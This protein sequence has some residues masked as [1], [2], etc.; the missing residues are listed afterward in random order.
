[1]TAKKKKTTR[2]P[3]TAKPTTTT[4]STNQ[5]PW[6]TISIVLSVLLVALLAVQILTPRDRGDS[7][8]TVP[9]DTSQKTK[10]AGQY[11][12]VK[13]DFYVMSQCPYGTQVVDAIAPVLEKLGDIV[14]FNL[15]FIATDLGNGNFNSL[16]GQPEVE[17]NI[18]QLCAIK[19][20][21]VNYMKMLVCV[22]K[23]A[24]AIPGN[25]E[26]CAKSTGLAVEKI[27]ACYE[28]EE[29][30]QLL[31][32][33][34]V[35]T[36]KV[37]ASGSPTIYLNDQLYQGGRDALS[38]TRAICAQLNN[39]PECEGLP[40][41]SRD[42]DCM[43]EANKI[44]KC[45]NAGQQ[46]AKC[47]YVDPVKV[48]VTV[49][50]DR[51]CV[52][53]DTTRILQV[54]RQL[55]P[56][57]VLK[58]VDVS[59]AEGKKL[60]EDYSLTVAPAY[61]FDGNIVK[62]STWSK[63]ARVKAAFE[64]TGDKYK[65]SDAASGAKH[66][67]SEEAKKAYMDAIGL[68]PGDGRPQID[69]F[70]MSYCPYGNQAEEAIEK[71]YQLLKDKAEYNPHYVIYSNYQGGGPQ[72]CLDDESKYCSM[73]G[74]QELNQNIRELCVNKHV[75][76]KEY[77]E[78]VLAANKECNAGNVDTCWEAVAEGLGLDT[79]K[80]KKCEKD[81]GLTIAAAEKKLNDILKITGSPQVFVEG[82][83]YAGAR[84]G[85]GYMRALCNKIDDPPEACSQI[86][87]EEPAAAAAAA[88][89]GGCS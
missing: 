85:A 5:N 76:I 40:A 6:K 47:I 65:L 10:P 83:E 16:H 44:G 53:C 8:T 74:V 88:P 78:F 68:T 27:R 21:P 89:Q 55:F 54:I 81:E 60:I 69:F 80:I 77:F 4:R 31:S 66:F 19:H 50:N 71:A 18:V 24:R 1:M 46:G 41:C 13:L 17:G 30:K 7:G 9:D 43:A 59:D 73:H 25:W 37:G 79:D 29:G 20:E 58:L 42:E 84:T 48:E 15:H 22:N 87:E 39:H 26:E 23:N 67:V 75:G 49:L 32:A 56:G 28:G 11:G 72:F 36:N 2:K 33:S 3:K 62:T 38:F 12:T 86:P 82:L 45:E 57:M 35:E 63:D 61:L 70:V 34:I 64:Q 51:T 14:D 52:T